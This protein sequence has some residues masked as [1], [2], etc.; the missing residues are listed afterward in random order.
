[1]KFASTTPSRSLFSS[2]L[3]NRRRNTG[4]PPV[5]T[6]SRLDGLVKAVGT[7]AGR[8]SQNGCVPVLRQA[9]RAFRTA[10]ATFA[11]VGASLLPTP[12]LAAQEKSVSPGINDKF[13]DPA[14]RAEEWKEK[15]ETE[16]REIFQ[17]RQR[18][19]EAAGVKP[20]T[21]VADIGAGTGLFTLPF[22]KATAPSGKV[23]AVEI[24]RNF[25]THIERR[26]AEEKTSNVQTVL[27]TAHSVE[28]PENSVDLVFICD[29]YH[30][31]EF[32]Q[33]TL[34]SIS[35]ALKPGGQI[36]LIDFIRVAGKSSDWVMGHV[37]AG[38]EV[39]EAEIAAAGFEKVSEEKNLLRENYFVRFRKKDPAAPVKPS[40]DSSSGKK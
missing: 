27:G 28:L 23:F 7:T 25:L 33:D 21:A 24:A 40:A 38:Q 26:A 12:H 4:V 10:A 1:M 14:M 37:R 13:L 30:H 29:T 3:K 11:V 36:V 6:G 39:F 17:Q 32:P 19:I 22:A 35:K 16:S 8:H 20:G 5:T 18:I 2:L 34:A 31:F 9:L 15:F